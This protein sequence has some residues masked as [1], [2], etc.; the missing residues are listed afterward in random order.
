MR[1]LPILLVAAVL[2]AAGCNDAK[3]SA[4]RERERNPTASGEDAKIKANLDK[5]S[6]EDRALAEAQKTCPVTDQ[7]LGSMG[8]PIKLMVKDQPVFVCC[9]SCPKEAT[10][11]PDKT[12]QKVAELKEKNAKKDR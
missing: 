11:D 1:F 5:L 3:P 2:V 6:P 4:D 10:K 7:P 12:L 8:V 9:S